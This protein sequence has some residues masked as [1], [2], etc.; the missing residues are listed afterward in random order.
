MVVPRNA[1]DVYLHSE[2]SI[3]TAEVLERELDKLC[4]IANFG[5]HLKL[6]Y[7]P[8]ADSALAGEVKDGTIWIY[9][10]SQERALA[11]F[12]HE[13]LD[14]L[15]AEA[16]EPYADVVNLHRI[17]LNSTFKFIQDLAYKR[18]ETIIRALEMIVRHSQED[19]EG[20]PT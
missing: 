19:R 12:R 8:R 18:K 7:Q 1:P 10:E 11:T 2:S 17:L 16:I 9:E 14:T 15:V 4:R 6:R 3:T 13:F 20:V 5:F